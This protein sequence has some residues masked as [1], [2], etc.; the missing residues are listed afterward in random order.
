MLE[1]VA[2]NDANVIEVTHVRDGIDLAVGQ[3]GIALTVSI[4]GEAH[5]DRVVGALEDAGYRVER[6]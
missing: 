4:R 3:T 1:L 5:G 2:A 6:T